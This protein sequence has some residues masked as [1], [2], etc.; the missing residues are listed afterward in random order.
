[1][2]ETTYP[3]TWLCADVDQFDYP[4][5]E[6]ALDDDQS[7]YD[8]YD[9][10]VND[11][12]RPFTFSLG[13]EYDPY[14]EDSDDRYDEYADE[15][16]PLAESM[17][18]RLDWDNLRYRERRWGHRSH[19]S[20]IARPPRHDQPMPRPVTRR[21]VT[22]L[23]ESEELVAVHRRHDGPTKRRQ[24]TPYTASYYMRSALVEEGHYR[25]VTRN[26]EAVSAKEATRL[27]NRYY[28][29]F[30]PGRWWWGQVR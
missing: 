28:E 9:E 5:W 4:A 25:W 8:R 30:Y 16:L 11:Y 27:L 10:N 6:L 29:A 17:R 14:D 19:H 7:I 12:Y 1:M 26:G 2:P 24:S 21:W 18:P 23:V 22:T 13:A 15:S 3:T 20:D